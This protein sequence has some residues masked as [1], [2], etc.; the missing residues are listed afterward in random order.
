MSE[1]VT[2]KSESPVLSVEQLNREIRQ[3]IE[4]QLSLVWVQGEISNFKAH[5]SGHFYFALKDAKS[6]IRAVMFRGYNSR[7]KFKPTD[8]LEVILRGRITVYEPR[9]EY[10]IAVES[11][12]PVGAG[13]LQKAFEQLKAKLKAEGLFENDKKRPLPAFPRHV[14]IVTSPTGAAIRDMINVLHRRNKSVQITLIPTLVQGAAAAPAICE[15]LEKAYALSGVDTIIVGRGGGSIEDMWCFNEESVARKISQSPVPIISAVGHEIDFTIADFVADLRA[16]TPSAAAE[17]VAKNSN[18]VVDQVRN[19][20]R[21]LFLSLQKKLTL[22]KQKIVQVSKRLVDP[23]RK[24]QDLFL[25]NDELLTRLQ[26]SVKNILRAKSLKVSVALRGL[27]SPKQKLSLL[28]SQHDRQMSALWAGLQKQLTNKKNLWIQNSTMLDSL[29]PLRVLDRGY[30]VTFSK[31]KI[32]RSAQEV[33][34]EDAIEVLLA[35][36]RITA[37]VKEIDLKESSWTSKKN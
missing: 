4:G 20:Q 13:A 27:G 34:K 21:L 26:S 30:A 33:K 32:I 28:K 18:D 35:Q 12:E 29:S 36:G 11:M 24:L 23:K 37:V 17:L 7:L 9:G 22:E 5:T 16:P 15:A 8:G 25:R 1:I 14:A 19:F 10:Q 2:E 31:N 3:L 6:S